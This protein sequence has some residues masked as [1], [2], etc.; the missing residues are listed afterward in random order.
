MT[1]RL[2]SQAALFAAFS[3]MGSASF[4]D[5]SLPDTLRL[6]YRNRT[7][8]SAELA[9][10]QDLR[11]VTIAGPLT[12]LSTPVFS[13][14]GPCQDA[15]LYACEA[16][17]INHEPV[18]L[19][20]YIDSDR[21]NAALSNKE[22]FGPKKSSFGVIGTPQ[23]GSRYVVLGRSQVEGTLRHMSQRMDS[24][25]EG[26]ARFLLSKTDG[27]ADLSVLMAYPARIFLDNTAGSPLKR[28]IEAVQADSVGSL[29]DLA[30]LIATVDW[31]TDVPRDCVDAALSRLGD[32]DRDESRVYLMVMAFALG[33]IQLEDRLRILASRVESWESDI[34]FSLLTGLRPPIST[35]MSEMMINT[36]D[37]ERQGTLLDAALNAKTTLGRFVA[38][39]GLNTAGSL[40]RSDF[41]VCKNILDRCMSDGDSLAGEELCRALACWFPEA[42]VVSRN[43]EERAR[44]WMAVLEKEMAKDSHQNCVIEANA[45]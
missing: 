36:L 5:A 38:L 12:K 43:F 27:K 39:R 15:A 29:A 45:V 35:G 13:S 28:L 42:T 30:K 2:T 14:S 19:I 18:R 31:T 32:V 1:I 40:R 9:S 24:F 44:N 3:L 26:S 8:S 34:A 7:L 10:Y 16:F 23:L 6:N 41:Q 17:S 4:A 37:P 21:S 22:F 33:D 11:V 25:R 20:F